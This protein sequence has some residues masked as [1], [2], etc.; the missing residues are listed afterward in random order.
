[1]GSAALLLV[2]GAACSASGPASTTA[3]PSP[4]ISTSAACDPAPDWLL[5]ALQD[6]LVDRG[7]TVSNAF[8]AQAHNVTSLPD[9]LSAEAFE[10]AWWVSARINGVGVRPELATWITNRRADSDGEIVSANVSARRY[11]SW[12][13]GDADVTGDG[14]LQAETCVGPIPES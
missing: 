4:T 8:L 9:E 1:M 13:H 3:V 10:D 12:P 6:G 2:V 14:R 11:S 5:S 7:A